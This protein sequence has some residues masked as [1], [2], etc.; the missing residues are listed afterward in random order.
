MTY[1]KALGVSV[2]LMYMLMMLLF[3]S[4]TMPVAVLMSLPLAVAGA[5]GGMTLTGSNFTRSHC[6]GSRCW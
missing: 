5:I 1:S 3:G 6:W 2:V 4:V